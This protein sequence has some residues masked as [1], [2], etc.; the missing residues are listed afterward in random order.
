MLTAPPPPRVPIRGGPFPLVVQAPLRQFA[1]RGCPNSLRAPVWSHALGLRLD[2]L[3]KQVFGG[4]IADADER[5]LA[6]DDIIRNDAQRVCDDHNFFPF[7]DVVQVGIAPD[8]N[9]NP[10]PAPCLR[11]LTCRHP[12]LLLL[13]SPP[14]L[15]FCRST[16]WAIRELLSIVA[17][18]R[19]PM[20]D[21]AMAL[22]RDGSLLHECT[23]LP[24]T[25]IVGHTALGE[26]TGPYPPCG[27]L[28]RRGVCLLAAPLC[29][30]YDDDY[31][32]YHV[33][34]AM[35]RAP[36]VMHAGCRDPAPHTDVLL[37][38]G[39][40]RRQYARY[41]CRLSCISTEPGTMLSLCDLFENLMHR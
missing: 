18:R 1:K 24:H 32:V 8:P 9:P 21:V 35:V 41:W 11:H 17:R 36:L 14:S 27:V 7:T 40:A 30:V 2:G 23:A 34:R 33:F 12:P 37:P 25:P 10:D 5:A 6:T 13:H 20:Q 29:Y 28:P 26:S 3:A 31:K 15:C 16:T 19:L 39:G 38:T 22:F 4:L